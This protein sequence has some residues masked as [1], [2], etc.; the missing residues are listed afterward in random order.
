MLGIMRMTSQIGSVPMKSTMKGKW[1]LTAPA[2]KAFSAV[3]LNSR[4]KPGT[5]G[6]VSA[7]GQ[8]SSRWER[9]KVSIAD[10]IAKLSDHV[11]RQ[12]NEACIELYGLFRVRKR[13]EPVAQL[14][15]LDLDDV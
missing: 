5:S 7:F 14:Q 8:G 13:S 3:A 12:T 1:R 9:T 4:S 11:E 10:A 15:D 2:A 6:W